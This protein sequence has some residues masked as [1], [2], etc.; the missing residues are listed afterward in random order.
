MFHI[1]LVDDYPLVGEGTKLII[2]REQDMQVQYETSSLQALESIKTKS[3]DVMIFDY[4]M[5][6]MDGFDLAKHVLAIQPKAN[7]LIYIDSEILPYMDLFMDSGAIGFISKMATK[8]QLIR[9]IR[10]AIDQEAMIPFTLL[11][12]IYGKGRPSLLREPADKGISINEKERKILTELVK[13]KTNKQ[14]AQSMFIG[15]RTLEYSLTNLFQKLGVHT[16][17][18]AIV[19]VKDMGLIDF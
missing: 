9:A 1:L 3:Y 10:C 8:D 7:V 14:I 11:K 15:Q 6:E 13:G 4:K 16:R 5:P 18:E 19:K 12:E 2:E 17:I